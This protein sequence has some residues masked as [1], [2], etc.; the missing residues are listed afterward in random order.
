MIFFLV[1]RFFSSKKLQ[2][3]KDRLFKTNSAEKK[4]FL[5]QRFKNY[6]FQ[7]QFRRLPT[8]VILKKQRPR[9]EYQKCV[10]KRKKP[11]FGNLVLEL[12]F[13]SQESSRNQSSQISIVGGPLTFFCYGDQLPTG[14]SQYIGQQLKLPNRRSMQKYTRY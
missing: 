10:V 8:K 3:T 12:S 1:E 11:V 4:L 2:T 6:F 14:I 13:S 5:R 9:N 7:N